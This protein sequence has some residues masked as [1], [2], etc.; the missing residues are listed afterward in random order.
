MLQNEFLDVIVVG[1]GHAGLSISYYLKQF[2]L[3]HLVFERGRIGES[4]QSQRWD[5][6]GMNTTN[7]IN[8]LQIN[9]GSWQII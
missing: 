8:L 5:S 2:G 3:E 9:F 4:W 6:F 1:A 7:K